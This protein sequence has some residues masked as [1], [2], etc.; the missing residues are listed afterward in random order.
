[1]KYIILAVL[2]VTSLLVGSTVRAQDGASGK[3][4]GIDIKNG[5]SITKQHNGVNADT[6]TTADINANTGLFGDMRVRQ[7]NSGGLKNILKGGD[8]SDGRIYKG[9]QGKGKRNE[10]REKVAFRFDVAIRNLNNLATRLELHIAKL[11]DKGVDVATA[12]ALMTTAKT[13][14]SAATAAVANLKVK[15]DAIFTANMEGDEVTDAMRTEVRALATDAKA[16]IIKAYQS[17][18][19]VIAEVKRLRATLDINVDAS[20]TTSTNQ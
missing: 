17:L 9:N 20:T 19:N 11:K 15:M 2:L 14:I 12:T 13:D 8:T 4:L 6:S 7:E 1:M 3:G 16:A 5:I 18:G 10:L